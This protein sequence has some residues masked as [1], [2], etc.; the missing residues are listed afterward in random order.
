MKITISKVILL[1]GP[2]ILLTLVS[3]YPFQSKLTEKEL[4][5]KYFNGL[6]EGDFDQIS[7]YLDDDV[8]V[9]YYDE[10]FAKNKKE[11][12]HLFR[13]D[14]VFMP[15]YKLVEY[16]KNG[17]TL[18]VIVSK[19]DKQINFLL[20]KPLFSKYRI[21]FNDNRISRIAIVYLDDTDF[22]K[23]ASFDKWPSKEDSLVS[24]IDKNY[25]ELSGF[26]RDR[27][28]QGRVNYL[29]SIELYRNKK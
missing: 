23:W 3:W 20:E 19:S 13:M 7:A 22:D 11:L 6:N 25:P 18:E 1:I 15:E 12:Y 10:A 17:S 5:I 2:I 28:V 4:V 8:L 21:R 26:K 9:L 16:K 14:S 27:T 29:K 24:W